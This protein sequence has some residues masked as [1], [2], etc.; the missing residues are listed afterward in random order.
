[1][2]TRAVEPRTATATLNGAPALASTGAAVRTTVGR[3]AS[4]AGTA[5]MPKASRM[6]TNRFRRGTREIHPALVQ[7][8]HGDFRPA[9]HEIRVHRRLV[10]PELQQLLAI[11]LVDSLDAT[12]RVAVRDVTRRVLV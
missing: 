3:A 11:E 10:D 9:D 8:G 7:P 6:I 5:A 1:M 2:V 4:P 12:G